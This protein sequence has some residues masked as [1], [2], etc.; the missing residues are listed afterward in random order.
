MSDERPTPE[1]M[2]ARLQ[3]EGAAPAGP[4]RGRLKLFV[5]YAA[6]VGK[7]YAML[8]AA[9]ALKEHGRD[10]LIGYVEPHARPETM[11]LTRGLEQLATLTLTHRGATV[12]EFDL[13]AAL[14]R[15]PDVVLVDELAHTNAPGV[16]HAKRWQDVEDLLDAGINVYSTV[17]IQHLESLND[18]VAQISGV[19]VRE[20]IPD[21]VFE[22]ADDV[23]LVDLPPDELLERLR[24][25]KIYIADQAVQALQRFFRKEN[26]VALREMA[27]RQTADRVH[28]DVE[29]ARRSRAAQAPWPTN[30][31]LLVCV[32]P[33]PSSAYVVRSAKRF[34]DRLDAEWIALH[35]ET[36]EAAR[37]SNAQRDRLHQNLKL[38]ESLG[39]E[40]V[41][42]TGESIVPAALDY[43]AARNVTKIVVGKTDV[44][45]RWPRL[46]PTLVDA[47][48]RASGKID[49]FVVRGV[50]TP[51]PAASSPHT[52][53][54]KF[55]P[56]LWMVL[57]LAAATLISWA[58]HA[59]SIGEANLVLTYLCAV[60]IV[61]ARC[62]PLQAIASAILA[63]LLFNVLFTEP[64]YSLTVHDPQYFITF[65]VMLVAGLLAS[66]LT[67]RVRYQA[68]VSRRSQRRTE[69]LYR[70]SRRL[71]AISGERRLIDEV[72]R[73]VAEVFDAHAVI[74]MPDQERRIRPTLGHTASF[75]ASAA[76]FAAAQWVLDHGQ[77]AGAGT[78]TL[79]SAAAL[80]LP[81][82]TPNGVVG[83]LAVQFQKAPMQQDRDVR[84]LLETY[85]TQIALALERDQLA[86][87][88]RAAQVQVETERMRSSLLSAV[89]HDL[90]TPLAAI[91]G[92]ASALQAADG[93]LDA[94]T[95]TDLLDQIGD[96]S[97]RLSRLV[98]NL[99]HMTRLS[100]GQI[101]ITRHW[102][103]VDEVIGSAL[104]RMRD[105]LAGR[106]IEVLLPDEVPLGHFDEVLV[107][108][109]LV[110]LLDNA[111]KY[112]TL[113]TPI[114]V[115]V[116]PVEN[117]ISIEVA[118]R[119]R[120]LAAG[121]EKRIFEMFYRGA[122]ARIDRRGAGLGLAI[123]Q[124]VVQ[125]HQGTIEAMNRPDGGTLVR[126]TLPRPSHPPKALEQ[127]FQ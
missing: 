116:V 76:E 123:C 34:A 36:P 120:G 103:P 5:G 14:A 30:E 84:N 118:D 111:A 70:L 41:Q 99:L 47:L 49:I 96:E 28:E 101:E 117:A 77:L 114:T 115:H 107:E 23:S 22:R 106:A 71:T 67:A 17:N 113:G 104:S 60:V 12:T 11:A 52:S 98:E 13:E 40:V 64:Y 58:F 26:L 33:S 83:V 127:A 24:E 91:A 18:I 112:S 126:F 65:A 16:R 121:D 42:I 3:T 32:G 119:G 1:Q 31:R 38:A 78:D 69:A 44:P 110:N 62:G 79:P 72:E 54:I 29:T 89:S 90:R 74:Y 35:V 85:A 125:A 88:S 95:R 93:N 25:G 10:V 61:A 15:R 20:T 81:L 43:A 82:T 39:A 9:Q 100:S 2:L 63:V 122:G 108:Q 4:R 48:I 87:A 19:T 102:Q 66:G 97:L 50:E 37:A 51:P 21:E 86:A 92:A 56:W 73:I 68:E 7:T 53:S 80:Y 75:A 109:A 6:G 8:K 105:Q 59:L 46:R 57:A 27:L 124:A 94:A 55:W 45:I